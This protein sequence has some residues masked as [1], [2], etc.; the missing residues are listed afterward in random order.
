MRYHGW[1]FSVIAR[2]YH[3]TEDF[4]VPGSYNFFCLFFSNVPWALGEGIVL[5]MYVSSPVSDVHDVFSKRDLS[6]TSRTQ[7]RATTV[8]CSLRGGSQTNMISH[9]KGGLW[10]WAFG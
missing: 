5:E 1:S 2:R 8:A 10:H 4:L 9:L 7:L 3:L 6:S